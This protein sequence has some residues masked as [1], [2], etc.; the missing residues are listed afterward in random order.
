MKLLLAFWIS[1]G[2]ALTTTAVCSA[3]VS[4]QT[5]IDQ[6]TVTVAELLTFR[7]RLRRDEEEKARFLL[8]ESGFPGQF[9]IRESKPATVKQLEDGRVEEV[10]DYVLSSYETGDLEIPPLQ[11]LISAANGDTSRIRTKARYVTVRTLVEGVEDIKDIKSPE[12]E[13]DH[14]RDRSLLWY[15]LV[16]CAAGVG[17]IILLYWLIKRKRR[18][19]ESPPVPVDWY[20]EL[21]KVARMKLLEKGEYKQY[22]SLLSELARRYLE[23][24]TRVEAM[25]RTTFE[26]VRDLHGTPVPDAQVAQVETFLSDADLVK[27]AK[28]KPREEVAV[29]AVGK[30]EQ[31]MRAIDAKVL[32]TVTEDSVD[33][34][35]EVKG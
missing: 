14:E 28:V 17:L 24:R 34:P 19:T 12:S 27:F 8:R 6:D 2:Y 23:A 21:K 10:T 30:A 25:E 7:I 20:A 22:Y 1:L 16:L 35:N 15:A 31:M 9:K 11:F 26:V 5:A 13:V 18:P 32:R 3:K 4:I 29:E 33:P